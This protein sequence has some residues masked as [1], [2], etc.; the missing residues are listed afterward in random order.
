MRDN[1]K[2]MFRFFLNG[3]S[4]SGKRKSWKILHSDTQKRSSLDLIEKINNNSFYNIYLF[5]YLR[6]AIIHAIKVTLLID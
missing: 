6:C 2:N 3:K 1:G 4:I 5:I